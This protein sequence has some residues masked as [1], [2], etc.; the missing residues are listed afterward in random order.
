ME[1]DRSFEETRGP[2]SCLEVLSI[3]SYILEEAE[4]SDVLA[5]EIEEDSLI[6]GG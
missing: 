6:K 5:E 2:E 4:I 3:Y 1:V